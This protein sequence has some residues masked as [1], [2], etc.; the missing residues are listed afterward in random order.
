MKRW[1]YD[2][3]IPPSA[4]RQVPHPGAGVADLKTY[5]SDMQSIDTQIAFNRL[6]GYFF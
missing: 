3:P 4:L 6:P 2:T 5:Y 1:T